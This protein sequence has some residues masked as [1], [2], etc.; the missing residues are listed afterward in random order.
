MSYVGKY[1]CYGDD[2]G[3]FCWGK[4]SAEVKVNSPKGVVPAFVLVN[5][6]TCNGLPATKGS[7]QYHS[8]ETLVRCDVLDLNRDIVEVDIMSQLSDDDLFLMTMGGRPE[9]KKLREEKGKVVASIVSALSEDGAA[10]DAAGK[11]LKDRFEEKSDNT[12]QG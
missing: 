9:L 3:G 4:I 1:V 12:T 10:M 11:A 7:I 8:R 6:M 5:R 2:K